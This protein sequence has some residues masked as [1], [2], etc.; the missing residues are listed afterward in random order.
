MIHATL[1]MMALL[2]GALLLCAFTVT[3][4]LVN[5]GSFQGYFQDDDLDNITWAPKLRTV[6]YL[7]PLWQ[8]RYEKSNFRPVGHYFYHVMERVAGMDF[9]RWLAAY[10]LLHLINVCLLWLSL[11]RLRFD[12]WAASA[13]TLA[14]ALHFA[15]FDAY[16]K[17]MFVFDVTC[18][19]FLLAAFLAYSYNHWLLGVLL[20]YLAYRGKELAILFPVVLLI[21]QGLFRS[22]RQWWRTTPYFALSAWFGIKALLW[23]HY[24]S[25]HPEESTYR[26]SLTLKSV[27]HVTRFYIDQTALLSFGGFL[28]LVLLVRVRDRRLLFGFLTLWLLLFP[29]LLLPGKVLSIYLY[30]PLIG[31]AIIMAAVAQ[32]YGRGFTAAFMAVWLCLVLY[33]VRPYRAVELANARDNRNYVADLDRTVLSLPRAKEFLFQGRPEA[34]HPWGISGAIEDVARQHGVIWTEHEVRD[35]RAAKDSGRQPPIPWVLL[36][37]DPQT[38]HVQVIPKWDAD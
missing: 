37:W 4:L 21:Y 15:V 34:L 32:H 31:F 3:F 36:I 38:H 18:C 24:L 10:N 13:G 2:R 28:L 26:L 30:V 9:P 27:W 14:F 8:F 6:D 12:P 20:F 17:P 16:W 11:R 29:M 33:H 1:S 25:Q 7:E 5:W 22:L 19:L 35:Y 23:Q